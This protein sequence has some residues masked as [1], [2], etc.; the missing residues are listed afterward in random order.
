MIVGEEIFLVGA[1]TAGDVAWVVLLVFDLF[2]VKQLSIF[3]V[4]LS[5]SLLKVEGQ[6]YPALILL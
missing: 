4:T 2:L 3:F 5:S 6:S 1:A